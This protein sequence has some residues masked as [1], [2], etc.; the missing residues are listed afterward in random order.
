[1]REKSLS[2]AVPAVVA[3]CMALAGL[4]LSLCA[5]PAGAV[6][7]PVAAVDP[8]VV[9]LDAA[10][11]SVSAAG[12]DDVE[13]ERGALKLGDKLGCARKSYELRKRIWTWTCVS[14]NHQRAYSL[15]HP[16]YAIDL[17]IASEQKCAP[18]RQV[19][20]VSAPNSWGITGRTRTQAGTRE[21]IMDIRKVT[22]GLAF[23]LCRP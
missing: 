17:L 10:A 23:Y 2:F 5:A 20:F 18:A 1:M 22:K 13:P 21:L 15:I 3:L 14:K 8:G 9:G 7:G 19:W 12:S 16:D 6:L 11:R 4:V